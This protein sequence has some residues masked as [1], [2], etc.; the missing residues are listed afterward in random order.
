MFFLCLRLGSSPEPWMKSG[1]ILF[2][3]FFLVHI[4]YFMLSFTLKA[5]WLTTLLFLKCSMNKVVLDWMSHF[6]GIYFLFSTSPTPNSRS[7]SANETSLMSPCCN[8]E[9]LITET[10]IQ[11]SQ[12]FTHTNCNLI[13]GG[14]FGVWMQAVDLSGPADTEAS[15][16]PG[17]PEFDQE[18]MNEVLLM[19]LHRPLFNLH[20]I[21]CSCFYCSW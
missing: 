13:V 19:L 5:L 15:L 9:H 17:D 8:H 11:T 20:L 2:Q 21:S 1:W 7:S 16:R 3:F 18:F 14:G 4:L 10:H 6:T 12:R